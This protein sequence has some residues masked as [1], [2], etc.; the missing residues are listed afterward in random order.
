MGEGVQEEE[1]VRAD[2]ERH[3]RGG[4]QRAADRVGSGLQVRRPRGRCREQGPTEVYHPHGGR[5]RAASG[6]YLGEG[7][8]A[9]TPW[10]L[11]A[12]LAALTIAAW[13]CSPGVWLAAA[14]LLLLERR[15]GKRVPIL[16]NGGERDCPHLIQ[17]VRRRH[18]PPKVWCL[19]VGITCRSVYTAVCW[20]V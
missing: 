2:Q 10:E 6:Q 19:R 5:D 7:L 3:H 15:W 8:R 9:T 13:P 1:G 17:C 14:F 11:F 4:D 18:R 12:G 20:S 16:Q